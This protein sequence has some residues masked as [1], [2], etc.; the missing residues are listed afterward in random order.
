MEDSGLF[1]GWIQEEI[2]EMDYQF[3]QWMREFLLMDDD[4]LLNETK[5]EFFQ[6]LQGDFPLLSNE[7]WMTS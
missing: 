5:D 4:A 1:A 7:H 6:Q 2:P 3:L